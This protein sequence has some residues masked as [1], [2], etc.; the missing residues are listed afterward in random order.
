M[1]LKIEESELYKSILSIYL[2]VP[3]KETVDWIVDHP[4]GGLVCRMDLGKSNKKRELLS[5]E[6]HK[7]GQTKHNK[8]SKITLAR[9]TSCE[10]KSSEHAWFAKIQQSD[11][12]VSM[13]KTIA[14]GLTSRP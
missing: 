7:T 1:G 2:W 14:N 11:W 13:L 5:L 3:V 6:R 8:L 10:S 9:S 4:D 12:L